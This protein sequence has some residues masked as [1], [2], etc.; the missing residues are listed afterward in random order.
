MSIG[1][2]GNDTSN[3]AFDFDIVS[4][5]DGDDTLNSLHNGV[6]LLGGRGNDI[7]NTTYVATTELTSQI[8]IGGN[9]NDTMDA[10][11]TGGNGGGSSALNF[12]MDGG[13]NNDT[14]T[15]LFQSDSD[16]NVTVRGQITGGFGSDQIDVIANSLGS[17]SADVEL[18]V[19]AGIGDDTVVDASANAIMDTATLGFANVRQVI[20]MGAGDDTLTKAQVDSRSAGTSNVVQTVFGGSGSDVLNAVA[21]ASSATGQTGGTTTVTQEIDGGTGNDTVSATINTDFEL[22]DSVTAS[23]TLT[24]GNGL[25]DITSTVNGHAADSFAMT[26]DISTGS[27]N[28]D[29][30]LN[31]DLDV[32]SATG[33]ASLNNTIDTGGSNDTIVGDLDINDANSGQISNVVTDTQGFTNV[34]LNSRVLASD[35][36]TTSNTITTADNADTI[37]LQANSYVVS[38]GATDPLHYADARNT[39]TSNGGN[40]VINVGAQAQSS[41]DGSSPSASAAIGGYA[42]NFIQSGTGADDI[43]AGAYVFSD[44]TGGIGFAQTFIN[45]GTGQDDIT[46]TMSS[47]F[48]ELFE[49]T[50]ENDIL[51]G[52]ANDTIVS[53]LDG[54]AR[55]VVN[56]QN[57]ILGEGGSDTITS[58]IDTESFGSAVMTVRDNIDGGAGNDVINATMKHEST[59]MTGTAEGVILGGLGNDTITATNTDLSGGLGHLGFYDVNGGDGNDIITV[60]GG[61]SSF[62]QG[63]ILRGGNG[64]DTLTG[65]DG[66]DFYLGDADEDRLVLSQ[67]ADNLLGGDNDVDTFVFDTGTDLDGNQFSDWERSFD[68]MEF[69]GLA[70]TGAA[71]LADDI[72]ALIST[73]VDNGLGNDVN[74]TFFNGTE[75]NFIGQG[76][77]SVSSIA[78][79]VDNSLTQLI[80]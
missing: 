11:V 40:D 42:L 51:G 69:T 38:T 48:S 27:G 1:S 9:G 59:A 76:T 44:S 30:N 49:V 5:L 67:G 35:V 6:I 25:D 7:M 58:T 19:D 13:L 39:V 29:V 24:G 43:T 50:L 33:V 15:G 54:F 28:D 2:N 22:L 65:G 8:Q 53:E 55:N 71:G 75:V 79:L 18:V 80:A 10:N 14:I 23:S 32:T 36:A 60:N 3:S 17:N 78:D 66:I 64:D 72:D 57:D 61:G 31:H 74:V 12:L 20:D 73:F 41:G 68:I 45:S 26:T 52:S 77:G 63:N 21:F 4:G 47:D 37:I 62:A 56:I 34:D 70:D 16:G 46:N